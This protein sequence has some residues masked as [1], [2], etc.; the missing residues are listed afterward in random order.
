MNTR[1]VLR[2]AN[3]VGLF[4]RVAGQVKSVAPDG[5]SFTMSDGYTI[6]RAEKTVTVVTE[7]GQAITNLAAGNV[8]VVNG[9]VSKSDPT[10]RVILLRKLTRLVPPETQ[11]PALAYYK[12]DETSGSTAVDSSGMGNDATL[13]TTGCTWVPGRINNAVDLNNGYVAAPNLGSGYG[14]VTIAT[15]LNVRSLAQGS[16]WDGTSISSSDGWYPG[17][18]HFLLLGANNSSDYHPRKI[19]LSVCGAPGNDLVWSDFTFTDDKLNTWVHVAA[20]YDAPGGSAEIYINGLLDGAATFAT[21]RSADLTAVKIGSWETSR[22][23]SGKTDDFRVYDRALTA[24]EI[25]QIYNGEL[26]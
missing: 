15:W 6:S 13:S 10:T 22:Y 9:V 1:S 11:I 21:N 19:Q 4:V 16:G 12:F 5:L 25:Q 20:V 24:S 7:M 8:V 23:F 18:V 26:S 14:Q 2:D 17:C 3:T